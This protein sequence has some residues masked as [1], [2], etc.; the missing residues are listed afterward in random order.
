MKINTILFLVFN[1]WATCDVWLS[2]ASMALDYSNSNCRGFNFRGQDLRDANF[3]ESDI[4]G[5][6]FR[7]AELQGANF[8]GAK[9]GLQRRWAFSIIVAMMM[10]AATISTFV[11]SA[12]LLASLRIRINHIETIVFASLIILGMLSAYIAVSMNQRRTQTISQ[13]L[14]RTAVLLSEAF[15]LLLGIA[16]GTSIALGSGIITIAITG[17]LM[18]GL[19]TFLTL[20]LQITIIST[21]IISGFKLSL[22]PPLLAIAA[23]MASTKIITASSGTLIYIVFLILISVSIDALW[24]GHRAMQGDQII[25]LTKKIS[26]LI[27]SIG[28]TTFKDATL[29]YANFSHAELKCTDFRVKDLSYAC[30]RHTKNIDNSRLNEHSI[31]SSSTVLDLLVNGSG[32]GKS[33]MDKNLES[34]N[35]SEF[36]LRGANLTRANLS[37]ALLKKADLRGA[38]LRETLATG[39]DF[40]SAK[41]TG[42]CLQNW[43][44]DAATNLKNVECQYYFELEKEDDNGTR[45]RRPHDPDKIFEPGDFEAYHRRSFDILRLMTRKGIHPE[46][47]YA[48]FEKLIHEFPGIAGDSIQGIWK[49]G[50]GIAIDVQV[51]A[52]TDK[53]KAEHTFDEAYRTS[54]KASVDP[55]LLDNPGSIVLYLNVNATAISENK[56]MS[57]D[58]II[59]MGNGNYIESNPGTYVQGN[60]I[61]MNQDLAQSALQIQDLLE[62]L[63]KQGMTVDVAQNQVANEMADEAKKDQKMKDKLVRWGQALGDATVNDVVK[64]VVKLAIRSAGIPLP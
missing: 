42:T 10:I 15:G 16:A 35:L 5:A 26:I 62:Q 34:S 51:P 6:N 41:L 61:N 20:T 36:D 33:Y 12:G 28:G 55:V 58:R 14:S 48:A 57:G 4:R 18:G 47:F 63:Q 43:N 3:S 7:N 27:S 29:T 8:T 25:A 38:I 13:A 40:T 24:G 1:L 52:G 31:L 60:Y 9:S 44:I 17:F 22:L 2:Y 50:N 37:K 11:T 30:Y 21:R 39:S 46:S 56:S 64:S 59:N 32:R 54:L 49:T 23:G 45:E 53:G 19:I